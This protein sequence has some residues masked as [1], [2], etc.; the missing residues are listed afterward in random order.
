MYSRCYQVWIINNVQAF[1]VGIGVLMIYSV[2]QHAMAYP[3]E[4]PADYE[5]NPLLLVTPQIVLAAKVRY[6]ILE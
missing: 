1:S 3:V 5:G 2:S 4:V 6:T